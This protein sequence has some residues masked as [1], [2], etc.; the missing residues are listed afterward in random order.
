MKTPQKYTY[1]YV[2]VCLTPDLISN[3]PQIHRSTIVPKSRKLPQSLS[4][5]HLL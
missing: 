2:C 4:T 3:R 5:D 1:V